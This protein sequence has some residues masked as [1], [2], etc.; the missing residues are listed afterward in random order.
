MIFP[1]IYNKRLKHGVPLAL[2]AIIIVVSLNSYFTTNLDQFFLEHDGLCF[3]RESSFNPRETTYAILS[4]LHSFLDL[5]IIDYSHIGDSNGIYFHWDDWVDLSPA[6]TILEHYRTE[7]PDGQ[8]DSNIESFTNVN[9]YYIESY[10]K[11]VLRGM[12][13]LYC[14][15]EIPERVLV[16]MDNGMVD[17]P[18]IDKKR[19]GHMRLPSNV[20]KDQLVDE[21]LKV[22][23]LLPQSKFNVTSYDT[24]KQTKD[25][26]PEDFIFNPDTEVLK[27]REKANNGTISNS[28]LTY[29]RFLEYSTDLVD[30]TDTYFKYPWI[31]TD[32]IQGK[33]HHF[34]YPF[35]KRYVSN[36]ERQ[37][38]VHHMVRAWFQFAEAYNYT[39]WINY[40]SLLGWAYNGV[41]LPWD[42]DVDIQMPIQQL[43][44]LGRK[45]NKTI[46]IENPRYGN[47]KYFLEVA[48]TYVK[49][50]NGKNFIDARFIDINSGLYIDIS[51]LSYTHHK[52]PSKALENIP[53]KER[54]KA[55]VVH[56]KNWNWH[57]YDELFPIRHT[58]FEGGS[59]YIPNNV[60]SI[61]SRKYGK[62]SYTNKLHFLN[63]NY[64][65]DIN[66][67]VPDGICADSPPIDRFEVGDRNSLSLKGACDNRYLQDEYS[68]T[69]ES[70]ERHLKLNE[71]IDASI[72]YSAD[73][74]GELPLFRKDAWD[75]YNDINE[76]LVKDDYWYTRE[77]IVI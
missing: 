4:Y 67:W 9:S 12:A 6:S 70:S 42:T 31:I 2:T 47:S 37:S 77:E 75:Y 8:C 73:V 14:R 25:V 59:V 7:Y 44:K 66:L 23:T 60:S 46:V 65:K 63:H 34:A 74:L 36:R 48:P 72:S 56:C 33:S 17:I 51:A 1:R 45:F 68:I 11:K 29:L 26:N 57:P 62:G 30:R 24:L 50:G 55:M 22:Q 54:S 20:K 35:F 15:K 69:R 58:Y 5:E 3:N 39:S 41:N 40:G 28:D 10:N 76:N 16:S 64:Q 43:D 53:P 27:L 19:L 32:L 52:P 13:D 21:L 18:V 71:D 49:Q 38:I 61:L